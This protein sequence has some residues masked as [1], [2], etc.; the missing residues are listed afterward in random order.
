MVSR[1][2]EAP[3]QS[4]FA[5]TE[6]Q[7]VCV[8]SDDLLDS[9]NSSSDLADVMEQINNSF[10]ACSRKFP[11]SPLSHCQISASAQGHLSSLHICHLFKLISI[12]IILINLTRVHMS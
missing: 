11:T 8:C 3:D 4:L 1:P 7:R 2:D 12:Y 5:V 10:P 6:T 9:H